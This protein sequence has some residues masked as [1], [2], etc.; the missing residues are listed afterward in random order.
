MRIRIATVALLFAGAASAQYIPQPEFSSSYN[1]SRGY[2]RGF[3]G[4]A[5]VD[6][7]IRGIRVFNESGKALQTV[8]IMELAAKPPVFSA[9]N[10]GYNV[11]AADLKFFRKDVAANGIINTGAIRIQKGKW[12]AV[13]GVCHDATSTTVTSSY[14]GAQPAGGF[15]TRVRRQPMKI[16]RLIMQADLRVNNGLGPVAV[17]G[18]GTGA[19][20]RSEVHVIG[21]PQVPIAENYGSGSTTQPVNALPYMPLPAYSRDYTDGRGYPRGFWFK[22]PRQIVINGFQ[23][24][25]QGART[26]QTVACYV[27]SSEPPLFP[28]QIVP[29]ASELRFF[30]LDKASGTKLTTRPIIVRKD[31][32]VAVLGITHDQALPVTSSYTAAGVATSM[33]TVLGEPVK[34]QRLISQ[35][36]IRTNMGLG[37]IASNADGAKGRVQVFINGQSAFG[38][39]FPAQTTMGE[40]LVGTSPTLDVKGVIPGAQIGIA[41]LSAG[42]LPGV[43]TPFGK[44]NITLPTFLSVPIPNG[45]GQVP[46][47][48]PNNASLFGAKVTWQSFIFNLTT[49]NRGGTNGTEWIIGG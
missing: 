24:P 25:D 44:L 34:I 36:A 10:P 9:T 42:R 15:D 2:P 49:N 23:V 41:L 4:Q 22:A 47:A 7:V 3:V 13:L 16:E 32:I 46:I 27:L 5:P 14:S 19:I 17:T 11:T 18:T 20:G 38:T 43:A 35:N 6:F 33:T 31:E 45:T 29:K 48:L 21:Q 26:L 37:G 39:S 8:S 30:A 1:D 40:P 28:M 12:F